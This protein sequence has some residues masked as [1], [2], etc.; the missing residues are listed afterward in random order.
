MKE[1]KFFS[2]NEYSDYDSRD[3]NLSR[4]VNYLAKLETELKLNGIEVDVNIHK[5]MD[6]DI[7]NKYYIK[8][9]F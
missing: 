6:I 9:I 5:E 4:L 7:D 3:D 2:L 8:K 1:D